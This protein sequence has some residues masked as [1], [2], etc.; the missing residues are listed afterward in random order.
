[1]VLCRPR[2]QRGGIIL[3]GHNRGRQG[4][5]DIGR[6]HHGVRCGRP[7]ARDIF[8]VRP[9]LRG[10]AYSILITR[11]NIVHRAFINEGNNPPLAPNS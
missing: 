9:E 8:E 7:A 3:E 10:K 6:R 11:E 4:R 2:E 5:P 1:M